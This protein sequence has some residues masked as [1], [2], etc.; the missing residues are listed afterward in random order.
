MGCEEIRPNDGLPHRN[1]GFFPMTATHDGNA[2]AVLKAPAILTTGVLPMFLRVLALGLFAAF[3]FSAPA[4]AVTAKEKME[5]CKFGAQDQKLAGKEEKA[6][7][8]KC[9]AA[10]DS[11]SA[12]P[13]KKKTAAP[14]Q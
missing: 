2:S 11:S 8:K 14:A 10:G 5:T 4:G 7:I 9:M 3:A 12:K 13:R 6:F 1:A